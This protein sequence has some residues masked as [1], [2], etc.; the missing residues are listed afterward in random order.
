MSTTVYA[1]VVCSPSTDADTLAGAQAMLA[2]VQDMA[3]PQKTAT[4]K[5]VKPVS[6]VKAHVTTIKGDVEV[7][8]DGGKTFTTA[9]PGAALRNGDFV[10][11]GLRSSV[12]LA[13]GYDTMTVYPITSSAS[14]SPPTRAPSP[15]RRCLSG[16]ARYG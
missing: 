6:A 8:T 12:V 5:T 3:A 9:T 11:T 4:T 7:S 13:F 16:S 2:A 1:Y 15:R 14:A 10:A